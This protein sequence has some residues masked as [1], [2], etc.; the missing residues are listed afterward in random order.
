M[1]I[2][3]RAG[4]EYTLVESVKVAQVMKYKSYVTFDAEGKP[5]VIREGKAVKSS[6]F[7]DGTGKWASLINSSNPEKVAKA[8]KKPENPAIARRDGELVCQ[9]VPMTGIKWH[10][11]EGNIY[12]LISRWDREELEADGLGYITAE[13][14]GTYENIRYIAFDGEKEVDVPRYLWNENNKKF[15]VGVN[16]KKMAY[17][18]LRKQRNAGIFRK[19]AGRPVYARKSETG[20]LI[21][22]HTFGAYEAA[23]VAKGE[24]AWIVDYVDGGNG[25]WE[26]SAEEFIKRYE[27]DSVAEDGRGIFVA[28]SARYIWVHLL[29]SFIFCIPQWGDSMVAMTNPQIN[30]TNP[31]DVYACSYVEFYGTENVE[32]AYELIETLFLGASEPAILEFADALE[33]YLETTF[34]IPKSVITASNLHNFLNETLAV[35]ADLEVLQGKLASKIAA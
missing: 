33:G 1:Q 24:G 11:I 15:Q 32:G 21:M 17:D 12:F 34:G 18:E 22:A 13:S 7:N 4:Y 19:N 35:P 5:V 26:V 16:V 28:K 8:L 14:D 30:L 2:F 20:E 9:F 10:D 25:G 23:E 27:F 3:D 29:G 31:D 6:F